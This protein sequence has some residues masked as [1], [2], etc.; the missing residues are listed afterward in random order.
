MSR[1]KLTDFVKYERAQALEIKDVM[2]LVHRPGLRHI[3]YDAIVRKRMTYK[4]LLPKS[5][6][7]VLIL[8][9]DHKHR[10]SDIGHFCLL[11]RHPRSGVHFFDPLGLGLGTVGRLTGNSAYLLNLLRSA[12]SH[13]KHNQTKFQTLAKDVQACGRHCAVRYNLASFSETEYI[14]AMTFLNLKY[15]TVVTLLTLEQ[16]L[17]NWEKLIQRS[18]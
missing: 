6:S 5:E 11:F 12:P 17:V 14:S 18:R 16:D 2:A 4:Q 9:G 10:N 7:G 3:E 8:F 13:V 15:D 1:L